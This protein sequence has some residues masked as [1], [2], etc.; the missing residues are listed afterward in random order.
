MI[1]FSAQKAT[2][3]STDTVVP[4][5]R[6]ILV[7]K[8]GVFRGKKMFQTLSTQMERFP[9][10]RL[11]T[12]EVTWMTKRRI[13]VDRAVLVRIS[14]KMYSTIFVEGTNILYRIRR[15]ELARGGQPSVKLMAKAFESIDEPEKR[16]FF[17]MRK[18]RSVETTQERKPKKVRGMRKYE[19]IGRV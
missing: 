2:L 7:S 10:R 9:E 6:I 15:E 19:G 4:M 3:D 5:E 16:G 17:G 11:S 14:A 13:T 8:R 12:D 18:S 1:E